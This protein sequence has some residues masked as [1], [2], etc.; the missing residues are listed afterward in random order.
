MS[1]TATKFASTL[2]Y[3]ALVTKKEGEGSKITDLKNVFKRYGDSKLA[4]QYFTIDL[5]RQLRARGITN[6]Y[7][8]TG[9]P[10]TDATTGLGASDQTAIG[11]F[12]EGIVRAAIKPFSNSTIDAAKTQTYLAASKDIRERDVHGQYWEPI[13]GWTG[14]YK[15]CH[16]VEYSALALDETEQ[17]KLWNFSEEALQKATASS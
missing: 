10:G 7:C 14:S 5:D 17:K 12:V 15:S 1:S 3:K 4:N 13:F 8:N 6:I 9:H 16:K 11:P 2:D